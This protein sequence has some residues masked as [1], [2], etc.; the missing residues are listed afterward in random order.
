MKTEINN[1][2]IDI[3]DYLR[4]F[5]LIGILLVN[6]PFLLKMDSPSPN[7]IDAS[8]QRFLY[9][10]V[11]G[12]FFT[13]FTF[14][15]GIGFYIFITRAKAKNYNAYLLFIRRLVVLLA[16]GCIHIMFNPDEAL[17]AY[18]VLGGTETISGDEGPLWDLITNIKK[19]FIQV[20]LIYD[21]ERP[22]SLL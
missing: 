1:N 8:Y 3:L 12:R 5:A 6:A 13:I 19:N 4:G 15:F 17:A 21:I 10:F 2:R 9:L 14:L 16:I 18:A 20:L 22:D 7:S 11:E